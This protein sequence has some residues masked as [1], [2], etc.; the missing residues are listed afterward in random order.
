MI[1]QITFITLLLWLST[2]M[3]NVPSAQI[4]TVLKKAKA[5]EHHVV[6][7]PIAIEDLQH[8][9]F[10][11]VFFR[12]TCPHCHHF[13]PVL[14]DFAHYYGVKIKAYSVDGPD[15]DNLHSTKMTGSEYKDYFLQGGYKAVVPALYLQNKHTDQVY[16]VLFGEAK[17]YQLAKRMNKLMKDIEA[18]YHA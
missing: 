14:K 8:N 1:K 12:S 7:E 15:L 2:T 9:Y 3:A 18:R 10:F 13:I 16:P 17:P 11:V 5:S 4:K 6:K